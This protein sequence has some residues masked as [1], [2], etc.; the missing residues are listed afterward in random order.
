MS[1]EEFIDYS[2]LLM[3][4]EFTEKALHEACLKR[5]YERVPALVDYLIEQGNLLKKWAATQ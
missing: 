1:Q 3:R 2:T 4:I 5:E